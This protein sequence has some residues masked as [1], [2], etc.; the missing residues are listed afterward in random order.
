MRP[1]QNEVSQAYLNSMTKKAFQK[2]RVT[3]IPARR[4]DPYN[5]D[6]ILI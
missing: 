4:C 2:P 1:K 3:K 6:D 5:S